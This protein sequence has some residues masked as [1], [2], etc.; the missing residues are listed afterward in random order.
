MRKSKFASCLCALLCMAAAASQAKSDDHPSLS[1]KNVSLVRYD[2][3]IEPPNKGLCAIDLE[4]WNTAIDF[5]VNQSTKLKLIKESEH[6]ERAKELWD[7]LKE[8]SEK[9]ST[10]IKA[11]DEKSDAAKKVWEEKADAARKA[12]EQAGENSSKYSSTPHLMFFAHTLEHNGGCVG[13][14]SVKVTAMLKRSEILSTGQVIYTPLEE[15]WSSSTLLV[16]PSSGFARF[17]IET[18]ETML[19]SF[20]NDWTLSQE[21]PLLRP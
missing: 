8:S 11:P 12:L 3:F 19:K 21:Y 7:K 13:T 5:V 15:I 9:F 16:G 18:S 17:V 20:V 10:L 1:L 4:A 14:V 2:L 6:S